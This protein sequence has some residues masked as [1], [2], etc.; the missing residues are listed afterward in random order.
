MDVIL[1]SLFLAFMLVGVAQCAL[2]AFVVGGKETKI[3][4]YP[5]SVYLDIACE[6]SFICSG[7]VLNQLVVLTAGHCFEECSMTNYVV[8]IKY[9]HEQLWNMR[10]IRM[11]DYIVHEKYV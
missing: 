8:N 4:K 9:G 1:L 3:A 10:S 7:S 11:K 2:E 6:S 5:H